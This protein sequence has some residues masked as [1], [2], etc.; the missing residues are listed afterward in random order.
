MSSDSY[1]EV[2][3]RKGEILL[4]A[5]GLD[6]SRFSRGPIAF[7]YEGMMTDVGYALAEVRRI[8]LDTGVG[9]TPL[10]E[11][12]N[13]THLVRKLGRKGKGARIF[14]KDEAGNPS[15]S[16][17]DRRASV[18]AYHARRLG[19]KGLVAATSGNHGA[20]VASQ[21]ARHGLRS[22]I[23]QEVFDSQG[24]GQ[25]EILEK[26]RKCEVLGAE[27]L[28]TTVGPELFYVLLQVLEETG[29]F[30]ASLYTPF[31]IAGIET[32]G[33]EIVEQVRARTGRDPDAVLITHAG[34]GNVTGIARG[35]RQAN[36]HKTQVVGVSVDLSGLHMASDHDFNRKSFTTGHTGFSMPFTTWPDR[37]DVPKNAARPL[38]YLDRFVT[39][40]QGEVFYVTELLARLEGLERGPAGNTSLAAA[41]VLAC[42]YDEDQVL[43]VS[44]TEYTGAGKSPVAQ[45]DF[46][47][48]MG[49]EVIAGDPRENQP[50]R[51]IVIPRY[52]NQLRV[53]NVDLERL[54]GSYVRKAGQMVGRPFTEEEVLFLAEDARCDAA[55]VHRFTE[56]SLESAGLG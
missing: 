1:G 31:S 29:Y 46:A 38:R 23:I 26:G 55:T 9:Q 16:F 51:R 49:I 28:Q 53:M 34:G 25:P 43:V 18:S 42:E 6:F 32:L 13:L 21:A 22:I 39:V 20:A 5:T 54:R 7:D 11:L 2:M 24:R 47:E 10:L 35:L 41:L 40:S 36:C 27:V 12:R 19:Y 8:Q 4:K 33:L 44:E 3:G 17:K 52:F 30:N 45:L 14:V 50:G 48:K 37:V 15:G 56:P